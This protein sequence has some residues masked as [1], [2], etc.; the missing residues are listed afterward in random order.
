MLLT[1]AGHE[2]SFASRE[3]EIE[4]LVRFAWEER[5]CR[6]G[7]RGAQNNRPVRIILHGAAATVARVSSQPSMTTVVSRCPA[8]ARRRKR[9]GRLPRWW[10]LERRLRN[11]VVGAPSH[12]RR[13]R[14]GAR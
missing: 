11:H 2:R 7:H 9:A 8:P 13:Q 10:L 12:N 6:R 4:S 3:A 14:L 1:E 5:A